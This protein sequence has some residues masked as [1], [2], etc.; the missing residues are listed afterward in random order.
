MRHGISA[1]QIWGKPIVANADVCT[2]YKLEDTEFPV[3][4]RLAKQI[5]CAPLWHL[6]DEDSFHQ[7]AKELEE[8]LADN[9]SK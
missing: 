1:E 3:T 9:C 7:Y 2:Q 4:H 8:V 6:A 5:V